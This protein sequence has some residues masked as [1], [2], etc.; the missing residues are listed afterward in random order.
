M[1]RFTG[2][3]ALDVNLSTVVSAS[4]VTVASSA[5]TD[6]QIA[7]STGTQAGVASAPQNI[8]WEAAS[9][10]SLAAKADLLALTPRV[11]TLETDVDAVELLAADNATKVAIT[12]GVADAATTDI[13][14]V[15]G[16]ADPAEFDPAKLGGYPVGSRVKYTAT[17]RMYKAIQQTASELP[18]DG[19]FWKPV[20]VLGHGVELDEQAARIQAIEDTP[21][22]IPVQNIVQTDTEVTFDVGGLPVEFLPATELITGAMTVQD[23]RNQTVARILSTVD[24]SIDFLND[25]S[26]VST[27]TIPAAAINNRGVLLFDIQEPPTQTDAGTP[28]P[29]N[30]IVITTEAGVLGN[31]FLYV[32]YAGSTTIPIEFDINSY[33][34]GWTGALLSKQGDHIA[35]SKVNNYNGGN[36]WMLMGGV[37]EYLDGEVAQSYASAV[38]WAYADKTVEAGLIDH[39]ERIVA[40]EDRPIGGSRLGYEVKKLGLAHSTTM[41]ETQANLVMQHALGVGTLV[42]TTN[43]RTLPRVGD[44]GSLGMFGGDGAVPPTGAGS[45]VVEYIIPKENLF[46]GAEVNIT[47]SSSSSSGVRKTWM[48]LGDPTAGG[49]ELLPSLGTSVWNSQAEIQQLSYE[50]TEQG[51][52]PLDLYLSFSRQYLRDITITTASSHRKIQTLRDEKNT[53]YS[54]RADIGCREDGSVLLA[55]RA[56][57][58]ALSLFLAAEG[59]F[60]LSDNASDAL[61][62]EG[63]VP[64]L[65]GSG[66]MSLS[67]FSHTDLTPSSLHDPDLTINMTAE[68]ACK[69]GTNSDLTGYVWSQSAQAATNYV[70]FEVAGLTAGAEVNIYAKTYV[71]SSEVV[72]T[73]AVSGF[74]FTGDTD[75]TGTVPPD[76]SS[77]A[78]VLLA[79]FT[80]AAGETTG[81]FRIRGRNL[82]PWSLP[83]VAVTQNFPAEIMPE[84]NAML[85]LQYSK[86]G[87]SVG[88]DTPDATPVA[89]AE[90][91]SQDLAAIPAFQEPNVSAVLVEQ[92]TVFGGVG[93]TGTTLA[94]DVNMITE[95][96]TVTANDSTNK[97]HTAWP[98]TGIVTTEHWSINEAYQTW[99]EAGTGTL[100]TEGSMTAHRYKDGG[101]WQPWSITPLLVAYATVNPS[102]MANDTAEMS[103]RTRGNKNMQVFNASS[104]GDMRVFSQSKF[105]DTGGRY[106]WEVRPHVIPQ[107]G[108]SSS[109][110]WNF[111]SWSGANQVL[112]HLS[113]QGSGLTKINYDQNPNSYLSIEV[114]RNY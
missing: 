28:R 25:G 8:K 24:M 66:D 76:F 30:K 38:Q 54:E 60:V 85:T 90:K 109:S 74:T 100:F 14:A 62:D 87:K 17:N 45:A 93:S 110:V 56:T 29:I 79:T 91:I 35:V 92:V 7:E 101:V 52:V 95:N 105:I 88:I 103:Y 64:T 23:K 15:R 22:G 77:A 111:T 49:V 48:Y 26:G 99:R 80:I 106:N 97:P 31:V 86:A 81:T 16:G 69:T 114:Y 73:Q 57:D 27:L 4:Q 96:S 51:N 1:S 5:G 68:N 46:A 108:S 44:S 55:S 94:T 18:T 41:T 39:D 70:Q 6:A 78:E 61:T 3:S 83:R 53:I 47:L 19:N 75:P 98:S 42:N 102:S 59:Y 113:P 112:S 21:V 20:S 63:T 37:F 50:I 67:N 84:T 11:D 65:T 40:Q 10:D 33:G 58:N 34:L 107:G 36:Q 71:Y 9:V 89:R 82:T 43:A 72:R 2:D 104:E 32:R 13:I 12:T